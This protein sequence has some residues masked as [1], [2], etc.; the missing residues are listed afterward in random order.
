MV[1][2][3][4]PQVPQPSQLNLWVAAHNN[5]YTPLLEGQLLPVLRDKIVLIKPHGPISGEIEDLNLPS[6]SIPGLFQDAGANAWLIGKRP[7]KPSLKKFRASQPA[8]VEDKVDHSTLLEEEALHE[9]AVE[10]APKIGD[11]ELDPIRTSKPPPAPTPSQSAANAATDEMD[12]SALLQDED[13]LV[14]VIHQIKDIQRG[15]LTKAPE[16][17]LQAEGAQ[18]SKNSVS[19]SKQRVKGKAAPK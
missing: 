12:H 18:S 6:I 4:N 5:G 1:R 9:E 11:A 2:L 10:V 13:E 15:T 17:I 3:A 7:N 16:R 14:N 8:V 19:K